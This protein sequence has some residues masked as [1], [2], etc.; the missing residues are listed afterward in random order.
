MQH[1]DDSLSD[2]ALKTLCNEQANQ[3]GYF[4]F[5]MCG[6]PRE[7]GSNWDTSLSFWTNLPGLIQSFAQPGEEIHLYV[8]FARRVAEAAVQSA[9]ARFQRTGSA[10][11]WDGTFFTAWDWVT[12]Q[13]WTA[14]KPSESIKSYRKSCVR[15]SSP[16][17]RSI[18]HV[19]R[20]EC[21]ESTSLRWPGVTGKKYCR[22]NLK[23]YSSRGDWE[24]TKRRTTK[25]RQHERCQ[26]GK[27]G[28]LP[29]TP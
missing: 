16:K 25:Q 15:C 19:T 10:R 17:Q 7:Q 2:E 11:R 21:C 18:E 12:C 23:R 13:K 8:E 14:R 1:D 22:R 20:T 4:F 3:G 29:T 26:N 5:N 24:H 6:R 9:I 28:S 27:S